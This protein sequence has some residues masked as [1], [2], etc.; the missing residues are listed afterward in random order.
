MSR[1][2]LNDLANLH[3][4]DKGT[5]YKDQPSVHGYALTYDSILTPHR[6]KAIRMLEVGVCMEGTT[7]GHSVRM[8]RD[9]FSKAELFAFDI[10]DMSWMETAEEFNGRVRFFQ[11]DQ[12]DRSSFLDMYKSFG[13]KNFDIILEDGSHK[14]PHQ[15]IS[16]GHLFQYVKPGGIYILEDISIPHH[17]VCCIRNDETYQALEHFKNTGILSSTHLLQ[18][19]QNYLE[20]QIAS[21]ELHHDIQDAYCT[22]IITKKQQA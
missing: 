20:N 15:M 8:W 9:Y 11:G 6:D 19:E 5:A 17:P 13:K 2:S 22:A 16:L 10:V 14:H 4:T 18:E 12:G 21:I 7:G 3:N 1:I